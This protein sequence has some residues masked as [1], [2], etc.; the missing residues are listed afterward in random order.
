MKRRRAEQSPNSEQMTAITTSPCVMIW[1]DG[2][3]TDTTLAR[4]FATEEDYER[5]QRYKRSGKAYPVRVEARELPETE[6]D[7]PS[8]IFPQGTKSGDLKLL[9]DLCMRFS[10]KLNEILEREG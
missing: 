3:R 4:A 7:K 8:T 9:R 6:L 2:S 5:Y 10:E 1:S